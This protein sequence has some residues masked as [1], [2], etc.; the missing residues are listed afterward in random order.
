MDPS[1][2]ILLALIGIAAPLGYYV[3]RRSAHAAQPVPGGESGPEPSLESLFTDSPVGCLEVDRDGIVLRVNRQECLLR[4]LTEEQMVGRP[5]WALNHAGDPAASAEAALKELSGSDPGPKRRQYSRANG[6]LVYVEVYQRS[7]RDHGGRAAGTRLTSV[8]ITARAQAEEEVLKTTQELKAIFDAFPDAFLRLDARHVILDY[9]GPRNADL[10]LNAPGKNIL[11]VLPGEPGEAIARAV[12]TVMRSHSPV[13]VEFAVTV[14]GRPKVFEARIASIHWTEVIALIRNVTEQKLA[15]EALQQFTRELQE[16]NDQLADALI[17]A[18]ESTRFKARFLAS[19]SREIRTPVNGVLGMAELM[20]ETPLNPEQKDYARSVR[21]SCDSLIRLVDNVL[22]LSKMESGKFSMESTTFDLRKTVDALVQAV[23]APARAKGIEVVCTIGENV[24]PAVRGDL[25][26]FRQVLGNLLDNSLKFTDRGKISVRAEVAGEMEGACTLRFAIQDTGIGVPPERLAHVFDSFVQG[27]LVP[28]NKVNRQA[29]S[30]R[31]NDPK[32]EASDYGGTGLGLAIAK[33]LVGMMRGEIG[34][35]SRTGQG[36]TFW[37]TAVFEKSDARAAQELGSHASLDRLNLS[38]IR[39]LL[40]EDHASERAQIRQLIESWG[41][42][43]ED[44]A[45]PRTV[46]ETL[47]EAAAA[48]HPFQIALMATDIQDQV[49]LQ[50]PP[51]IR[52]DALLKET[53]LI[54][55]TDSTVRGLG[56]VLRAVGFNAYVQKPVLRADLRDT[57]GET[58]AASRKTGLTPATSCAVDTPPPS[59]DAP[60]ILLVEDDD[61]N[62][63]Y[64]MR[65]LQRNGFHA[66]LATDGRR[67]V[68]ATLK[69]RYDLVLMDVHMPRM[70]GLEATAQIRSREGSERHTPILGLTA[71]AMAGDRERFLAAGMDDYLSKP[72][73]IDQL[74]GAIRKWAPKTGVPEVSN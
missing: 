36:S 49:A 40:A 7:L 4:G 38:N 65:V 44:L 22:S 51:S 13:P 57:I 6:G 55:L 50:T 16:K 62:Q 2:L 14:N 35:D 47:R 8:D 56:P 23:E 52:S 71:N 70:N 42:A 33:Q 5:I 41:G 58:V 30:D 59:A 63:K 11:D 37:F 34:V 74:L 10:D 68:E 3:S 61:V 64:V 12:D 21:S 46:I 53:I 17:A 24:P 45:P 29:R 39:V 18:H 1:T 28:G 43:C 31:R 48:G 73:K 26:R 19:M 15:V 32:N 69:N 25:A 54:A 9:Q 72:V 27:H 20:L 60:R 67:A 66:D